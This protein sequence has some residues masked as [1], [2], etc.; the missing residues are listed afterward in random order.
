MNVFKIAWRSI[1]HRGVGSVLTIISMALGVMMVVAVLSIHGIVST[2][3][4]NNNS[5]GYNLILGARGGGLQLTM[6]TVYYL[7][8]P[9]ENVPYEFYLAFCD[10]ETRGKDLKHSFAYSAVENEQFAL[11][12][13]LASTSVPGLGQLGAAIFQ[14]AYAAQQ[15][16]I[17]GIN[18]PGLFENYTHI[19][20]PLC[21]GDYWEV[22]DPDGRVRVTDPGD[23]Q[24]ED[25]AIFAPD[26]VEAANQALGDP[27]AQLAEF[28]PV[29]TG[30]SFRCVGTTPG[31]FEKLLLDTET[32]IDNQI[33]CNNCSKRFEGHI[34]EAVASQ[35]T[36]IEELIG[37]QDDYSSPE[38]VTKLNQAYQKKMDESEDDEERSAWKKEQADSISSLPDLVKLTTTVCPRCAARVTEMRNARGR[39]FSFAQGRVFKEFSQEYGYFECVMG[40]AVAKIAQAKIGDEI[41]PTHGD[42]N[43]SGAHIHEQPFTVVGIL[44]ETNTPNDRAVYLNMEGFFLMEDHVK[45]IEDDSMLGSSSDDEE[46]APPTDIEVLTDP[47][48]F[49]E[50]QEAAAQKAAANEPE[51]EHEISETNSRLK[52][53]Q[54]PI[55]QREVTSV[56]IRTSLED[57]YGILVLALP[58]LIDRG[59]LENTLNWSAFRPVASQK[60]AQAVNPVE[61]I[62]SLFALFVDPIQWL[63]LALTIMICVVSAISILVGIYNSMSQRKHEIAVI[64][65]LGANR[66]KVMSIMLLEALLLALMGGFLGWIAG[67][68]LNVALSPVVEARTGVGIGFFDFAPGTPIFANLF[69]GRFTMPDWL[70]ELSVSPELLLIPG[71]MFL[72]VIV[73]IYPALSAYKTDV[74]SSLGK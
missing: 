22:R 10:Q 41:F 29:M 39:K 73:G 59:D 17:M 42:P 20:V 52:L 56:L 63:L 71:L 1:Q 35:L 69:G 50:A 4:K 11:E 60:A 2:S 43:S 49:E 21:M 58:P 45:P 30:A 25:E 15:A 5:F 18:E 9:V 68:G 32:K 16:D 3:F 12:L 6:N 23:T 36:L 64:R 13:S 8:K 28:E 65:A 7:S 62:S 40:S 61:E 44:D 33:D 57:E 38:L 55:E 14:D 53:I 46:E 31:F 74:S 72:A 24:L 34:D 54:L 70:L 37:R 19:V 48:A 27:D 66:A 26:V 47:F 51:T 67:H